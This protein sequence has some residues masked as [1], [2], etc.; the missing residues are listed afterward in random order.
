MHSLPFVSR[1][2][3]LMIG[4]SSSRHHAVTAF[5]SGLNKKVQ[6]QRR[7]IKH[8]AFPGAIQI[9]EAD[10]ATCARQTG[11]VAP[12]NALMG[13]PSQCSCK[14]GYPQ[15]FSLDPTPPTQ[16]FK[17]RSMDRVNSGMLKLTCPLVVNAIDILEDEGFINKINS[18][19]AKSDGEDELSKCMNDAHAIHSSTRKKLIFGS[20]RRNTDESNDDNQIFQLLQSKLGEKGAEYFLDAGVA[21]ANPLSKK[22]DVKCLHAWMADYL[23]RITDEEVCDD[24]MTSNHPI[25]EAILRSLTERGV[26]FTGTDTCYLVCSGGVDDNG[27]DG[28]VTIPVARNKQRKKKDKELERRRRRQDRNEELN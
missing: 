4:A 25:G 1:M 16:Q 11:Q 21:G 2:M 10:N 7:P 17:R 27:G 18:K 8:S 3:A 23:F 13:K 26:D 6:H 15:A 19:L 9:T 22:K 12:G 20:E 5:T 24:G 28:A 14:H